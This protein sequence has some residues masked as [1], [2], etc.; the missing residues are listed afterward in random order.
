MIASADLLHLL[1]LATLLTSVA[2]CL[3]ILMARPLRRIFGARVAYAAWWSLPVVVIA[4]CLPAR[5]ADRKDTAVVM[6]EPLMFPVQAIA[7]PVTPS[8]APATQSIDAA[9]ILLVLWCLGVFAM[10]FYLWGQQ[11]R[12]MRGLGDIQHLDADLWRAQVNHGLPALLGGVRTRIVLPKDFEKRYDQEQQQLMLAHER[13]HRGRGDHLANLSIALLRS[14]FWFNPLIHWAA[15]RLRHDQEL[16]CDEAVIAAHPNSRRAY[17]EAM[18]KTLMADRQAPLGCHW[19]FSHPLTERIMQ[20]K[21]PMPRMWLRRI[22]VGSVA[23]LALSAGFAAWSSQPALGLGAQSLNGQASSDTSKDN[24][25]VYVYATLLSPGVF[26]SGER[27]T[28]GWINPGGKVPY[29]I[30]RANLGGAVKAEQIYSV[31]RNTHDAMTLTVQLKH[32][33]PVFGRETVSEEETLNIAVEAGRDAEV[34]RPIGREGHRLLIQARRGAGPCAGDAAHK[35][36]GTGQEDRRN[37][38]CGKDENGIFWRT[39]HADE[40]LA[41][42]KNESKSQ[43]IPPSL[44]KLFTDVVTSRRTDI[45]LMPPVYQEAQTRYENGVEKKVEGFVIVEVLIGQ[46]GRVKDK[47]IGKSNPAGVFDQLALDS[48]RDV[49]EPVKRNGQAVEEWIQVATMYAAK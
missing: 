12:F 19:G 37:F 20:L 34:E 11:R 6:L 13:L 48:V 17:G 23:V 28:V 49:Y 16:A 2:A 45:E 25:G 40:A 36:L 35:A 15:A 46:D 27:S 41:S 1:Y 39:L 33:N 43:S 18:L 38:L 7:P 3:L 29:Q 26:A 8:I 32:Y 47:R 10:V 42:L 9:F 44:S 5:M 24:D 14:V 21:S 31:T 4:F 30:E 22:G